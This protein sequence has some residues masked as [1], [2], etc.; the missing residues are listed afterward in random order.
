M[1]SLTMQGHWQGTITSF[2]SNCMRWDEMMA[3]DRNI[4]HYPQKTQAFAFWVKRKKKKKKPNHKTLGN[5]FSITLSSSIHPGVTHQQTHK[6]INSGHIAKRKYQPTT[7]SWW[8]ISAVSVVYKKDSKAY[9]CFSKA[10]EGANSLYILSIFTQRAAA[11]SARSAFRNGL[12]VSWS[13][14]GTNSAPRHTWNLDFS[15]NK[16]A[17]CDGKDGKE[18]NRIYYFCLL[19]GG[20]LKTYEQ[21][22]LVWETLKF[23]SLFMFFYT[24]C[25]GSYIFLQSRWISVQ[26]LPRGTM[27]SASQPQ[28]STLSINNTYHVSYD[29]RRQSTYSNTDHNKKA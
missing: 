11:R 25:G 17:C 24:F 6:P 14:F 18:E 10:I 9:L 3:G 21:Y 28:M 5:Y 13:Q 20:I 1:G 4:M 15:C 7:F 26:G 27:I 16:R 19:Y 8:Q 22:V 12:H 2:P 23:K 29:Y